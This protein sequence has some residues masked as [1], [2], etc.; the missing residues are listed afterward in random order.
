MTIEKV[1]EKYS[2]SNAELRDCLNETVR[3]IM[4]A[5]TTLSRVPI[6]RASPGLSGAYSS[7]LDAGRAIESRARSIRAAE[8][9]L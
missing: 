4:L 9:N 5:Q 8:K 7:L 3:L 1:A 2:M 6:G